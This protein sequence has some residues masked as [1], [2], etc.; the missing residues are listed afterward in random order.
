MKDLRIKGEAMR[1]FMFKHMIGF[2]K[3]INTSYKGA[4]VRL[5]MKQGRRTLNP[6]LQVPATQRRT[7]LVFTWQLKIG[8]DLIDVADTALSLYPGITRESL[9]Q[10]FS[11]D[12]GI[13]IQQTAI[14]VAKSMDR[15]LFYINLGATQ[16]PRGT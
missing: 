15:E 1:R 12:T 4:N 9:S 6:G 8:K 14:A 2:V 5:R 10:R 3:F 16:D 11:R 7:Y 13:P